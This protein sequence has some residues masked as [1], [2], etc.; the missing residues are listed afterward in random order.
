MRIGII[1]AGALG[2]T[3]AA[4]LARA[5]HDVEVTARGAGLEAIRA[6]GIRLSGGYGDAHVHPAVADRLTVRPDL[7]LVCTKAQ[8]AAA[9]IVAN[10]AV[11]DG[12]PVVVVQNGLDGVATAERL[13][14]RSACMGMLSIIA[15]N[16]T[17]PGSVRV[18]TAAASYLG[19]GDGPPDAEVRRVASLI[20]EAVPVVAVAN[21]RG[22]QWT[23]LVVNMLNAVPA[24]VGRSVQDVVDDPSLRRVVAASMRECVRVGIARGIRFGSLQGLG[25]RRLRAFARLPLGL[26]QV[27]PWSMR[28][29]MG[30]VPNLGSTQQ[31]LRRG[32]PTEVDFLNGAVVREAR[33]A[34]VDAP[35]NR[36]LTA[37]VHEVEASGAPLPA[38][39][40]AAALEEVGAG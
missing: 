37:L 28:V 21:F 7:V 14:P 31:S 34:G 8:D 19:R 1:G 9:A 17:E 22:A 33:A 13:L 2:G 15:A 3:F 24:I 25:D 30:S 16:Y 10:G 23:K 5:G 26:A 35:V 12:V 29:R 4:L 6:G 32:Q 36:A 38:E 39:R 18:T 40:V 11:I 27:L 20:S